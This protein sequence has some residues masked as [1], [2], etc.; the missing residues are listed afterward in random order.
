MT[1][2]ESK[3]ID[4]SVEVF[5]YHFKIIDIASKI[6]DMDTNIRINELHSY[7]LYSI[8]REPDE[9]LMCERGPFGKNHD[10]YIN[11][12]KRILEEQLYMKHNIKGDIR[13]HLTSIKVSNRATHSLENAWMFLMDQ[14]VI[15]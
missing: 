7:V 6:M 11:K 9:M 13:F 14:G 10:H 4:V 8:R 2:I 15:K 5:V 3:I 1:D 12:M